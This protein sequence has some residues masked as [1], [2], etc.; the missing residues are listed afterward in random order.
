MPLPRRYTYVDVLVFVA[1]TH[2]ATI[3]TRRHSEGE[4]KGG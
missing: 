4:G 2:F 3:V 1:L